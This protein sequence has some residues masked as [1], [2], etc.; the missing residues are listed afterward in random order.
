LLAEPVLC[1]GAP[2]RSFFAAQLVNPHFFD[3]SYL[4][5]AQLAHSAQHPDGKLLSV[6]PNEFVCYLK[7]IHSI[8]NNPSPLLPVVANSV[9]LT[10]NTTQCE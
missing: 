8:G 3:G 6:Q 9:L 1:Q 10:Y 4:G 2:G 7:A 5:A